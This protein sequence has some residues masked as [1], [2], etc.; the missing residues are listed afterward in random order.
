MN[1]DL[2]T[3]VDG[4]YLWQFGFS[5]GTDASGNVTAGAGEGWTTTAAP[6][7][8]GLF[9]SIPYPSGEETSIS[10]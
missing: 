3:A 6:N 2:G 8:V 4:S 1:A 9:A 7:D 10:T 5:G